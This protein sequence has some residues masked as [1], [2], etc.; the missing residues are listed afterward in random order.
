VA[1]SCKAES[2]P[3]PIQECVVYASRDETYG[4]N[5]TKLANA[6]IVSLVAAA[7]SPAAVVFTVTTATGYPDAATGNQGI[8]FTPSANILVDALGYYDFQQDGFEF[9]HT[10]GIY[11]ALS[12]TLLTSVT[13]TSTDT[14]IGDFRYAGITPVL[15]TSGQFYLVV[16]HATESSMDRA[17]VSR[18]FDVNRLVTYSGYFFNSDPT[19]SFPTFSPIVPGPVFGPNFNVAVPEPSAT[20]LSTVGLAGMMVRRRKLN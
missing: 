18:D 3:L 6:I 11:D 10:V 5:S 2:S 7:K 15:L 1:V 17:A 19:F 14:L 9:S 4:M 16:G 13:I 8:R 20:P 12:Q